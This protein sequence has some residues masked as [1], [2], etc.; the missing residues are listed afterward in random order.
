[1]RSSLFIVF[2]YS[3]LMLMVNCYD[4][5]NDAINGTSA[6]KDLLGCSYSATCSVGG[7]EGV[8]VS[9]SAGCCSGAVT[10]NLCPGSSDI[11][12][13]T[14][15]K[16]ST[17]SGSGTCVQ[18]SKCSGTSVAGYC[19]GP[20]DLQCC[21][22]G[23]PTPST[24]RDTI[25]SR[26]QHWVDVGVPYSQTSYYEGYRQDCSGY[27]SMAWQLSSSLTTWDFDS[28]CTTIGK[29]DLQKGDILLK[30]DTHVLIFHQWVDSDT[31][32]EYAEHGEGQVAS[33][34]TTSFSYYIN[35]G[36]HPCRYNKLN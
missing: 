33:H 25:I 19:T 24:T 11:K 12:C 15:A 2:F 17:P 36:Y 5:F 18:T 26:A 10:A 31:F 29:N 28:I 30:P 1:M 9:T 13:C 21:I 4:R 27:V 20:S 23:S 34:D 32:W 8:C 35:N 14:S 3:T 22:S 7:V 16:C 6:N